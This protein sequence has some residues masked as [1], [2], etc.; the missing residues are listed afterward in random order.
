VENVR[1]LNFPKG[2][3]GGDMSPASTVLKRVTSFYESL[4]RY[5]KAPYLKGLWTWFKFML[6]C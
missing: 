6:V 5:F 2:M 1:L 3:I 4:E